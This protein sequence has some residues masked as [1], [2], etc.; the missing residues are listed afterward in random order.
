M[1]EIKPE[2]GSSIVASLLYNTQGVMK[3]G[4]GG[5]GGGERLGLNSIILTTALWCLVNCIN[6]DFVQRAERYFDVRGTRDQ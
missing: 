4:G 3:K 6:S 5:G 1:N 2:K